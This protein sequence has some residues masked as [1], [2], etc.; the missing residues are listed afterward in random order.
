MATERGPVEQCPVRG[1][2]DGIGDKWSVL[3]L[4]HLSHADARFSALRRMIPDVSQR[5]L[6]AT[7]RKVERD[8]LVWRD[9]Q[10]TVPAT[11]TYGLTELGRTLIRHLELLADW[12]KTNRAQIDAARV[13][14]DRRG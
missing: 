1:V 13:S 3:V 11:V 2:I 10:P 12:A 14:F 6:T 8:G 5:M 4:L 7:L 9:V